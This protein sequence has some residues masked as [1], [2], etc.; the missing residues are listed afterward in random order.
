M[1]ANRIA[2]IANVTRIANNAVVKSLSA[3]EHHAMN[4]FKTIVSRAAALLGLAA[5]AACAPHANAQVVVDDWVQPSHNT[6]V[7][8]APNTT[9]LQIKLYNSNDYAVSNVPVKVT[10]WLL[11]A[12]GQVVSGSQSTQTITVAN[13]STYQDLWINV[14]IPFTVPGHPSY[15]SNTLHTQIQIGSYS[16][17][18]SFLDVAPS[19]SLQMSNLTNP[20]NDNAGRTF[21]VVVTNN[22]Y[23]A[24]TK[25]TITGDLYANA[26]G[27][28]SPYY[29]LSGSV[30]ALAPGKSAT[31]TFTIPQITPYNNTGYSNLVGWLT[32]GAQTLNFSF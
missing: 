20:A 7:T 29:S 28:V 10:F 22:G 15:Y 5:L 19:A 8:P 14:A 12:L 21:S 9:V 1:N 32:L 16:D 23:A 3:K 6:Y 26:E 24:S 31:V 2:C 30:P 27:R 25:Q 13:M 17:T 4:A 18:I 11:N